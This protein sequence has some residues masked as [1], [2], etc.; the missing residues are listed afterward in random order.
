MCQNRD[1]SLHHY[2]WYD[3]N[4]HPY[5]KFAFHPPWKD[6]ILVRKWFYPI[7]SDIWQASLQSPSTSII[8]F[9]AVHVTLDRVF[10]DRIGIY[11]LFIH[12][13]I[14]IYLPYHL[15]GTYIFM[16]T[17]LSSSWHLL[18]FYHSITLYFLVNVVSNIIPTP[19]N[20]LNL[21]RKSLVPY[22]T[23]HHFVTQMGTCV[24]IS[25]LKWCLQPLN[26][27]QFHVFIRHVI[28][29]MVG[30]FMSTYP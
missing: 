7:H 12:F 14:Y 18:A 28:A 13:F 10:N 20:A 4:S 15:D 2:L 25:V 5:C 27:P 16:S 6:V 23:M 11:L 19:T 26:G 9:Y 1:H 21:L 30:I 8:H 3:Y 29:Y 17:C 24:H 22:P